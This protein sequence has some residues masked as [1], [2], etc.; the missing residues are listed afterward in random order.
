MP[1]PRL[2]IQRA[3]ESRR[4]EVERVA[5]LGVQIYTVTEFVQVDGTGQNI[6]D[7]NFP[8]QF[9]EKP[10]FWSGFVMGPNEAVDADDIPRTSALVL[11]WIVRRAVPDGFYYTGARIG[12]VVENGRLD[13]RG[14]F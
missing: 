9:I 8:V 14:E 4:G 7:V 6:G 11:E 12:Y 3:F 13:Q 10:S 5:Q 1:D 2:R